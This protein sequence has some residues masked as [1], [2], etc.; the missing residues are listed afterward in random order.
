MSDDYTFVKFVP[1]SAQDAA[2]MLE[3][4]AH[5]P[6][7]GT[8][9]LAQLERLDEYKKLS[10]SNQAQATRIMRQGI[11]QILAAERVVPI[12]EGGGE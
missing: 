8:D 12:T 11:K 5:E 10:K 4:V 9:A 3:P 6:G 2:L 1:W 7:F